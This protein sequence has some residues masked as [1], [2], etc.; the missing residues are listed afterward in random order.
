MAGGKDS[1]GAAAAF[2]ESSDLP[3][4]M[5][6]LTFM[7]TV[8]APSLAALSLSVPIVT[9]SFSTVNFSE[10]AIFLSAPFENSMRTA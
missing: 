9:L 3:F 2:E 10:T 5:M 8:P 7:A 1:F 6:P 4:S